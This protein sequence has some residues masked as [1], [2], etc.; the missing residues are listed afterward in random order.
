[1]APHLHY[2]VHYKGRQVNPARYFFLELTP[3]QYEEII[4]LSSNTGQSLD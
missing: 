2:E 1:M 4:R 3:E